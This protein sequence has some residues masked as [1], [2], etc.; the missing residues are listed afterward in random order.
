VITPAS[1]QPPLRIG[2]S[3]G[4]KSAVQRNRLRRL[5]KESARLNKEPLLLKLTAQGKSASL[6]IGMRSDD[7]PPGFSHIEKDVQALFDEIIHRWLT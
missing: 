1:N 4:G 7:T 6:V 2:F 3:V 5:I